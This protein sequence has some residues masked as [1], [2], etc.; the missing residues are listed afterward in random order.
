MQYNQDKH[1]DTGWEWEGFQITPNTGQDNDTDW[2]ALAW[3]NND[4]NLNI[5]SS[6]NEWNNWLWGVYIRKYSKHRFM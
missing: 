3:R 2:N 5:N 4:I 6:T 1:V